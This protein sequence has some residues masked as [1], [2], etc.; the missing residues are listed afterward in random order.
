MRFLFSEVAVFEVTE[1]RTSIIVSFGSFFLEIFQIIFFLQRLR[2]NPSEGLYEIL[3][4]EEVTVFV[5][6]SFGTGPLCFI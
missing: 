5:Q 6:V 3:P 2:A 4:L 1:D